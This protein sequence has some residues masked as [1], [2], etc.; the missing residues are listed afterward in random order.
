[1]NIHAKSPEQIQA[2]VAA[3]T[4]EAVED[5]GYWKGREHEEVFRNIGNFAAGPAVDH[6][7]TVEHEG[8]LD[9]AETTE[10]YHDISADGYIDYLRS[11]GGRRHQA[12]EQRKKFLDAYADFAPDV[13]PLVT[14]LKQIGR[15]ERGFHPSLLGTGTN[16]SAHSFEH[17]G[18][19]YIVKLV[20]GS[21]SNGALA[22]DRR[23]HDLERGYGLHPRLEQLAAISY[24]D[25]AAVMERMSGADLWHSPLAN[26]AAI[27]KPQLREALHVMHIAQ[28]AGIGFDPNGSNFMYSP[29][30]GFG[31]IDYNASAETYSD[32]LLFFVDAISTMG[33]YN[34]AKQTR[35]DFMLENAEN[36]LRISALQKLRSICDSEPDQENYTL[37]IEAID[38]R[39]ARADEYIRNVATPGW[40]ENQLAVRP[41]SESPTHVRSDSNTSRQPIDTM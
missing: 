2:Q 25:G 31:F 22:S 14:E 20:H 4:R 36:V 13:T 34:D 24:D 16:A 3:Y 37:A 9:D 38:E 41:V 1:M 30:D 21:K 19:Q 23:L 17:G 33:M 26:I 29:E 39:I 10:S 35:E 5:T 18:K 12:I 40:L 7:Y 6:Y 28:D 32:K 11:K 15:V 27:S 8:M